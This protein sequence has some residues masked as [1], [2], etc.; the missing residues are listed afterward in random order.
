MIRE[1]LGVI[2]RDK[3]W[4]H[5][6]L[7]SNG[8]GDFRVLKKSWLSDGLISKDNMRSGRIWRDNTG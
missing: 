6:R 5:Q 8:W 3:E 7:N 4:R 1:D 2:A